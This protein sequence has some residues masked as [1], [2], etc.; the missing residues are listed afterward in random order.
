[1]LFLFVVIVLATVLIQIPNLLGVNLSEELTWL[2]AFKVAFY[3]LPI[4]FIATALYTMFYG[5]GVALL[6]YPSLL[7][8]AK[9]AALLV[10]LIIEW[11]F[12]KNRSH[13][14]VELVGFAITFVGVLTLMYKNEI[15]NLLE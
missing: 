12:I 5:K 1:M 10:A 13:N 9:V 4:T 14:V 6:S 3:T 7:L 2:I 8:M 11:L 15:R